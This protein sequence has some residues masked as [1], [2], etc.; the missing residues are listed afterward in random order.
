MLVTPFVDKKFDAAG[1]LIDESFKKAVDLFV[2]EF[3]WLA[4]KILNEKIEA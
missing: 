4:E 2:K 3:V 1:N